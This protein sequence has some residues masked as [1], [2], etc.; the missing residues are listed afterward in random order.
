[1]HHIIVEDRRLGKP[2]AGDI[3]T[4]AE[5]QRFN[6]GSVQRVYT[7]PVDP[8]TVANGAISGFFRRDYG[9]GHALP[10]TLPTQVCRLAMYSQAR[11]FTM[12]W[13]ARVA[14]AE[15]VRQEA[16]S[17]G[18]SGVLRLVADTSQ[19]LPAGTVG[20]TNDTA[21]NFST[22]TDDTFDGEGW[23]IGGSARTTVR[24]DGVYGFALHGVG[25]GF[26]VVWA[27]IS[28]VG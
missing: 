18:Y 3:I 17:G 25:R 23:V 26:R 9:R 6:G 11:S 21:V 16:K 15:V 24:S 1:M 2:R 20:A 7:M 19:G 22:I 8:E 4:E 12:H 13:C 5:R 10:D 27:A 28:Q 14:A